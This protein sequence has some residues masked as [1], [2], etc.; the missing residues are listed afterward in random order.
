[1]R[2][3]GVTQAQ[4]AR[5]VHVSRQHVHDFAKGRRRPS[6][7]TLA[8]IAA[9]LGVTVDYLT[10]PAVSEPLIPVRDAAALLG[11]SP[12]TLS[13]WCAA[14]RVKAVKVG[15]LWRIPRAEVDRA[16]RDGVAA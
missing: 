14:G 2:T 12:R 16:C 10:A 1:M 3:A 15:R 13:A 11:I 7:Q 6:P 9:A 5:T 4:L 8:A